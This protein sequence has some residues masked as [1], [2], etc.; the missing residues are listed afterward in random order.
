VLLAWDRWHAVAQNN[1]SVACSFVGRR[2]E[3]GDDFISK[4]G[5]EHSLMVAK[6]F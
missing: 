1:D 2:E 3:L 4:S 6:C 5:T